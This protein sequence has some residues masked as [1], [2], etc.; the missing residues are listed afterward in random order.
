LTGDL[1]AQFLGH[2]EPQGFGVGESV[3][4]LAAVIVGGSA[5]LAGPLLGAA[6]VSLLPAVAGERGF[7]VPVC[8]GLAMILVARFEPAGLAGLLQKLRRVLAAEPA[9]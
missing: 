2:L 6:F 7:V 9:G 8:L 1:L 3:T 4:M 5:S